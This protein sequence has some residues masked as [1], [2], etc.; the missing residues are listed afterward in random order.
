MTF[1]DPLMSFISKSLGIEISI[2]SYNI[3]SDKFKIL[4]V[5][6]IPDWLL[7]LFHR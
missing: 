3:R 2:I 1:L 4:Y 6:N 7:K 5:I